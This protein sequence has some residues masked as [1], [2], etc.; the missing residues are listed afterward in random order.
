[1][2]ALSF[3]QPWAEL[4]LLG[5]KTLDL[6]TYSRAYRGE[7][8]IHVSKTVERQAC[9]QHGL[10]PDTLPTG[11][12]VGVVELVDVQPLDAESYQARRS[13]HLAGRH[14]RDDLFGWELAQPRRLSA[15]VPARGR[16]SLFEVDLDSPTQNS[17]TPPAPAAT[18]AVAE[19]W[20]RVPAESVT[21]EHPFELRVVP[22]QGDKTG[23]ESYGLTLAQRVVQPADAQVGLYVEKPSSATPIAT[24]AGDALRAVADQV[25]DALRQS[26]YRPTDLRPGRREPFY[27]PEAVGVRLGLVFLAV[28]PLSKLSRV[29]AISYGVRRMPL[30][31]VYYWYSKCTARDTADR[32]QKALRVLLAEE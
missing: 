5:R 23:G 2:K 1:M 22:G 10:D 24:L 20:R 13:E 26:D 19:E 15:L 16:L 32:A 17:S 11:G 4:I 6:R 28:K 31:E 21:S 8:A 27:L 9:L 18:P 12:I 25:L 30:E 7:L 14:F 3:R 29:E